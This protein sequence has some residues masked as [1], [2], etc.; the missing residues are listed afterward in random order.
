MDESL[1]QVMTLCKELNM[2]FEYLTEHTAY[3]DIGVLYAKYMNEKS[4]SSYNEYLNLDDKTKVKHVME[5]GE[6]KP[7][8]YEL[9]GSEDQQQDLEAMRKSAMRHLYKSGGNYKHE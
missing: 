6:P 7:F 9:V 1:D 2:S 5:W 4:F 8:I 3:T